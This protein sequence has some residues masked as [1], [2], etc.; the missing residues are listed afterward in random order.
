MESFGTSTQL[1]YNYDLYIKNMLQRNEDSYS[2][3]LH[4]SFDFCAFLK[5]LKSDAYFTKTFE[6][7]IASEHNKMFRKCPIEP[8]SKLNYLGNCFL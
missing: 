2:H 3:I 5:D 1:K 4:K 6:S 7:M 8:V